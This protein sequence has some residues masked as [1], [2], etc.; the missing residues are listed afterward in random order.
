MSIRIVDLMADRVITARPHHTVG[1]VRSLMKQNRI[2][3]V[4]VVDD[5]GGLVGIVTATDLIN[6]P[7]AST[8]V[9][10][11][12]TRR[13]YKLPAYNDV[14]A[15]ARVMRKH[16]IHHVV[17][18]HEQKVTGI[19]S[20]FDLLKVVEESQDAVRGAGKTPK[21]RKK[22]DLHQLLTARQRSREK[23]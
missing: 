18:T 21:S 10:E 4:P 9:S 14:S 20:S 23:R 12:M 2:L 8:P 11:I 17:V 5:E 6:D 3:A 15:A 13:V 1:H 19:I 7:E 22:T 16:R